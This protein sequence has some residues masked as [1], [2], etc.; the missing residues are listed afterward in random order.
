[1][2]DVLHVFAIIIN[3]HVLP[4]HV[5]IHVHVHVHVHVHIHVYVHVYVHVYAHHHL[6]HILPLSLSF[7]GTDFR[8]SGNPF[9]IYDVPRSTIDPDLETI[10][11]Y[12]LDLDIGDMEIYDYPPDASELGNYG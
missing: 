3:Y 12:P 5:H 4:I 6:F 9:D 1:M 8:L 2:H 10:Y 7:S 11:D